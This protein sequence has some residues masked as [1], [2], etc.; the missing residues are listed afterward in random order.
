MGSG[1]AVLAAHSLHQTSHARRGVRRAVRQLLFCH[2][3]L[4][5]ASQRLHSLLS[6]AACRTSPPHSSLCVFFL[7]FNDFPYYCCQDYSSS[8]LILSSTSDLIT[9]CLHLSSPPQWSLWWYFREGASGKSEQLGK[10]LLMLVID[11]HYYKG[12]H[13]LCEWS[14]RPAAALLLALMKLGLSGESLCSGLNCFVW[15][16]R[17]MLNFCS[18]K[19]SYLGSSGLFFPFLWATFGGSPVTEHTSTVMLNSSK[20]RDAEPVVF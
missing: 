12:S 17:Q 6:G 20:E 7:L 3:I 14:T 5:P 16:L 11:L 19:I 8:S 10:F 4:S 18:A 2:L 9:P 15:N 13:C 1:P